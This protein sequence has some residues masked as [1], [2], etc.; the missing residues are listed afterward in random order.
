MS[1]VTRSMSHTGLGLREGPT[2][3]RGLGRLGV[4]GRPLTLPLGAKSGG[5]SRFPLVLKVPPPPG[6]NIPPPLLM[7]WTYKALKVRSQLLMLDEWNSLYPPPDYYEYP[8]R[9]APHPFMGLDKF[10]AG[11]LHQMRAHKSYLAAHPSW[12][13]EDPDI[14]CPRC[15]SDT[16]TFDHAI[17]Q[18][19]AKSRQRGRYLEPTLSLR[20]DSPLWDDKEH[21]HSLGLYLSATRT[22][23]PPEMA[24]SPMPSRTPSPFPPPSPD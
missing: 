15:R 2:I 18:C 1:R 20:A 3:S 5:L 10:I 16:E 13:S 4:G 19:P 17:L 23:F 11:R 7:A 21:L 22:G 9:L 6:E 24:P 12:W 14:S 8:C